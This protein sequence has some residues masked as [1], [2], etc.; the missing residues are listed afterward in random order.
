MKATDIMRQT[1][2]LQSTK[3]RSVCL[4]PVAGCLLKAEETIECTGL[5]Q[6]HDRQ[7]ERF[8]RRYYDQAH[9]YVGNL[10]EVESIASPEA[11]IINKFLEERGFSIRLDELDDLEIGVAS[12][13][14]LLLEWTRPGQMCHIRNRAFPAVRIGES[15]RFSVSRRTSNPIVSITAKNG[16]VVH[17]TAIDRLPE[18]SMDTLEL[19]EGIERSMKENHDFEGVVFPMIDYDEEI[20]ISWIIG[21][22]A[23]SHEGP[24]VINQALQQ[25]RFRM[26]EL[27][28]KVESAVAMGVRYMACAQP[29]KPDLV[30]DKPFLLWITRDSLSHP[31]FIGH[32]AEDTWKRPKRL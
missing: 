17:M 32:F 6:P 1:A 21:L 23:E 9:A 20:D 5:W 27:G 29:K 22:A 15:H 10:P 2:G 3:S 7:Q 28:A 26:N 8:L 31:L 11:G 24:W 30:I 19:V 12:V 16:D 13:F 25:T 4:V 14:K 18:D